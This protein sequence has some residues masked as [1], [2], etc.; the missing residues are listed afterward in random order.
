MMT[1]RNGF[2]NGISRLENSG[3]T[4]ESYSFNL[5]AI[6][7]AN[8]SRKTLGYS[9]MPITRLTVAAAPEGQGFVIEA[10][11]S[12]FGRSAQANVIACIISDRCHGRTNA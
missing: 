3:P 9:R 7:V 6:R 10:G 12:L 4:G 8:E 2:F 11:D 1:M 5:V